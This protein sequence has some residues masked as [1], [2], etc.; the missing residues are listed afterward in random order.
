MRGALL[1]LVVAAL[2]ATACTD[3]S[4]SADSVSDST[5]TGAGTPTDPAVDLTLTADTAILRA[6]VHERFQSYNVE[7]VEVTGGN[8]WAP[9]DA[10]SNQEERPPIDLGSERLRNLARELGPAYVRVSG[11][12]AN[13]TYFDTDGSTGGTPPE[14]FNAV[15]TTDQWDGVDAFAKAVDGEIVTSFASSP[16]TRDEN[17]V[18]QPDPARSVLEFSRDNGISLAAAEFYNEPSLNLGV[19]GTYDAE[20]FGRDFATFEA[21]AT[22]VLPSM[23]IVGPGAVDD[24]TPLLGTAPVIA[25][26]DMLE[27]V[28]P[29]FDA[30]SYHFYPKVSE[31]CSSDEGPE[32]ALS[33]EFL[34]R[35]EAD[36]TFYEGLR[37]IYEPGVPMWITETAQA[38]CGGDRWASTYIDVFRYLDQMGRLASGDDDVVFHNTLAASDYGLIDEDGFEPRPTYWAALLWQRLMGQ[39]SLT[40]G[41]ETPVE[42]LALYGHCTGGADDGSVSYLAIN[43]SETESRE[44]AATDGSDL[45]LLTSDDLGSEEILLN[46]EILAATEEGTVPEIV[47][48]TVEGTITMPPTSVAF[49]VDTDAAGV[50][51]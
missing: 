6:T 47:S 41:V 31:R 3:S 21:L 5:A 17:G 34:S 20:A 35:V 18:W 29:A 48:G 40:L 7:M 39:R 46:G 22:E 16:G 11:T 26:G 9:Y 23:Q 1:T 12:W 4:D 27:Q 49:V 38:A 33:G 51:A 8:F 10:G 37:D 43:L 25:A 42:D 2:V 45:Y 14:G 13:S 24:E 28:S 36:S 30:F 15:L 50:C 32:T 19:I 44:V